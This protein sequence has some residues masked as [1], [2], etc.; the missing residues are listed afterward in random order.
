L[1]SGAV[2]ILCFYS[3]LPKTPFGLHLGLF[4]VVRR[5]TLA[6]F[7]LSFVGWR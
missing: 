2:K 3:R 7:Y 5:T 4:F 1:C 6:K